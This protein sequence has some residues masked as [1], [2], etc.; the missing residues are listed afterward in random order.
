MPKPLVFPIDFA[1]GSAQVRL[2]AALAELKRRPREARLLLDAAVVGLEARQPRVALNL[3]KKLLVLHPRLGIAHFTLGQTLG[4]L[5]DWHGAADAFTTA[6]S[7]DPGNG[8]CCAR[9][10]EAL[11]RIGSHAEAQVF[12]QQALAHKGLPVESLSLLGD[13]FR[14]LGD[15]ERAEEALRRALADRED[16][17]A[18]HR[19]GKFLVAMNRRGEAWAHHWRAAEL[20]PEDPRCLGALGDEYIAMGDAEGGLALLERALRLEPDNFNLAAAL[21]FAGSSDPAAAPEAYHRRN[22]ERMER[23]FPVASP[24]FSPQHDRMP[25]RRLRIGYLSPDFRS[26]AMMHWIAPLLEARNREGFEVLCFSEGSAVDERTAHF[27]GL[28]DRWYATTGKPALEVGRKISSLGVD[29]LVDLAGATAGNRLDVLALKPSPV[30]VA[31]LGF[32]RSTGLK[33]MDWRITT[34]LA[35]P[36]GEVDGWSTERIWRLDTSFCYAPLGDAPAV[37]PLPALERGFTTF[38]FLGNPSRVG[39]AFM[40]AAVRLLQEAPRARL[41]LLCREGEDQAHK[42]FKRGFLSRAG[43]DPERLVFRPR[44]V[45]ESRFLEYYG[46]VDIT[47]NSFPADGGTTICESLWMG[48]PVLALDR[49]EALRHT[50]RALLTFAGMDG[51][52]AGSLEEWLSKALRWEADPNGLAE[53]RAG[54]RSRM[55]ASPI[56]DA[57]RAVRAIEEAYRDMWREWCGD[58]R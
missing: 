42:D 21:M 8:G 9:L 47:L 38:G 50:G 23:F 39:R 56:C 25:G 40:E 11:V 22:Q 44:V 14:D 7:M 12:A 18:H 34:A 15:P 31:M 45:P 3:L 46:E 43:L 33:A 1:P 55:L 5:G 13:V 4:V 52:V 24:L 58:P 53:V 49:E 26:H 37:G 30:Q 28:A 2:D 41:M 17:L 6:L 51:W 16:G 10:A 19:L 27:R 29:I 57:P 32:D 54:L 36:P 48:V 35:D 20:S